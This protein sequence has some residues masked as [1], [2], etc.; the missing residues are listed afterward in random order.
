MTKIVYFLPMT[1]LHRVVIVA[2]EGCQLLDVTGPAAVFGA[3]NEGRSHQVY[4]VTI[5]SPCMRY[6]LTKSFVAVVGSA[7]VDLWTR[8]K[9]R[10]AAKS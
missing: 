10:D 2:Y 3:A 4:D 5:V 8:S 1:K 9:T 6:A 7:A